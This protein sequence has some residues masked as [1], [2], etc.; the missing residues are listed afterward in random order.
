[1]A[2]PKISATLALPFLLFILFTLPAFGDTDSA[3]SNNQKIPVWTNI[4]QSLLLPAYGSYKSEN[5][6]LSSIQACVDLI[7][8][9]ILAT[10][11]FEGEESMSILYLP[12]FST[13]EDLRSR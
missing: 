3:F 7:P 9:Y 8:L 4:G 1:M 12:I 10:Q 11:N 6:I 13:S 5:Y 2:R